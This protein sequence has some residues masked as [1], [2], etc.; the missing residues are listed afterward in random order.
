MSYDCAVANVVIDELADLRL[1]TRLLRAQQ[2]PRTQ[3]HV[4]EVLHD[5]RALCTLSSAGPAEHEYYIVKLMAWT[6]VRF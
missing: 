4:A 2:L 1:R 3:M 5:A 6:G